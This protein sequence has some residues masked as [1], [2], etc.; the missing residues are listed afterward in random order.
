MNARA[1]YA[2]H[3]AW[4][5]PER[6]IDRALFALGGQPAGPAPGAPLRILLARPDLVGD[7]I[8][9][10]GTLR[11]YRDAFPG[12]HIV[13]LVR[14]HV[15]ELASA[16]PGPDDVWVLPNR[17]FRLSP[18]ERLRWWRK[19]REGRFDLAV[20]TMYGTSW[21]H[22]DGLVGWTHAPRRVAHQCP[23]PQVPRL[24]PRPFFTELVPSRGAHRFTVER[25]LDLLE[26]LAGAR[27]PR[28][29]PVLEVR[30]E[31]REAARSL[32]GEGP[33]GVVSP[34]ARYEIKRWGAGNFAAALL[35]ADRGLGLRWLVAGT[36]A[37]RGI[38]ADLARRLNAEGI[39]SSDVSGRTSLGVLAALLRG[40]GVA[41]GNDSAPAHLA[42]AVGTPGIAVV[43]GGHPGMC[44]PYPGNSLTRGVRHEL[45]CYGCS[46]NCTRPSNE[47][48]TGVAPETVAAELVRTGL[49]HPDARTG[50]A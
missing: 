17:S 36:S 47:C 11:S 8:L 7:F 16:C 32:A 28:R 18:G 29:D 39:A 26:H 4:R 23:D 38:C 5:G 37:E 49:R 9:F 10:T 3:R 19:M 33:Y 21:E 24:D 46:W 2:A 22:L 27:P 40:A 41:L 43:G 6:W 34:G 30:E 12:A 14:D 25:D 31:W 13:L 42:A 48:I 45:P 1:A 35:R 20:N 15:A 50:A 44:Y